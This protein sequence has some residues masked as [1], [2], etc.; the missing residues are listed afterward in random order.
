MLVV[1]Y[2]LNNVNSPLTSHVNKHYSFILAAAFAGVL[3]GSLFIA[4]VLPGNLQS[5]AAPAVDHVSLSEMPL[6]VKY[7]FKDR[8]KGFEAL[9]SNYLYVDEEFVDDENHCEFCI[10]AQYDAGTVGKATFAFKDT[11]TPVGLR[12]STTLTFLVRGENGNETVTILAIGNK[13]VANTSMSSADTEHGLRG[14]NFA[15]EKQL[16]LTKDW[17][18]YEIDLAGFDLSS[19]TH[20]FA[21]QLQKS[22]GEETQIVYLDLI[23]FDNEKSAYAT[24]LN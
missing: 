8:E 24:R 1:L 3:V 18:K 9:G 20:P 13:A 15:F 23:F 14:V 4:G 12:N 7:V 11:T 16:T 19:V 2:R 5:N 10:F 22:N 17:R 6:D 21:F